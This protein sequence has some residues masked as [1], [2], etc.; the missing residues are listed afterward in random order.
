MATDAATAREPTPS[1]AEGQA[2]PRQPWPRYRDNWARHVIEISR[3]LQNRVRRALHE[4]CRYEGLR[5]SFAPFLS[6]I[7]VEGR[8]LTAIAGELG[9]SKQAC[10]QL[11][12]LLEDAG[13]L[14]RKTHPA[15]RRSKLVMLTP[16]GRALVEDA[17]RIILETESAYESLVG[18][19][20]YRRFV[21]T[22]PTLFE[23]LGIPTHSD[24]TLTERAHQSVG[25]L[26]LI[27]DRIERRIMTSIV[28]EGHVG[29]KRSHGEV[30]PLIGPGGGRIHE[31]ARTQEVSRQ[32]VSAISR[33]LEGL[34]YL[35]RK[36][37]PRDRRGVVWTL[38]E[39]GE[40]LIRD[41]VSAIDA[42]DAE[43]RGV[44][45]VK[46]FGHLRQ[47]ASGLF[48]AIRVEAEILEAA[49]PPDATPDP[50]TESGAELG[51][52]NIRQ[53]A[54]QLRRQLG[55]GDSARLAA[56]LD[57]RSQNEPRIRKTT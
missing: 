44:L 3:D 27:T 54:A 25:V 35:Q 56:L 28:A 37:D 53:L 23:G 1:D 26:P 42:L 57:R 41:S 12:N 2:R 20:E 13:Y 50:G 43:C 10:S 21:A 11:A 31:I 5:P 48:H 47:V 16:R 52:A 38:T 29:L 32:A 30:L 14:E 7:W 17:V 9:I 55:S 33:E 39:R 24:P 36:A 46:A 4:E 18:K 40:A 19:A 15:D 49:E 6:L 34:G 45:G 8:A 22:L 51:T